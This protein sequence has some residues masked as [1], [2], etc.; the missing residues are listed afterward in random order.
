MKHLGFKDSAKRAALFAVAIAILVGSSFTAEAKP[1][2]NSSSHL[3]QQQKKK[4]AQHLLQNQKKKHVAKKKHKVH[5]KSDK[6]AK[7]STT[8]AA[9]TTTTPGQPTK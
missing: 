2:S 3:L 6:D 8:G 1:K 5:A 7:N 9:G 4:S